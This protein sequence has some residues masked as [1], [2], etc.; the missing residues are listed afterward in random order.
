MAGSMT[1]T[2]GI[3]PALTIG[4]A[5]VNT[6]A[7]LG[8]ISY[9]QAGILVSEAGV[10]ASAPVF[11]GRINAEITS[12]ANTGFAVAN[13]N[14]SDATVSFFF[15]DSNGN[16]S[17]RGSLTLPAHGQMARFLDQAPFNAPGALSGTFAFSSNVP[18]SA[19]A[20]RGLINERS[21]FLVT[22]LPIANPD[23]PATGTVYFPHFADGGG[24][25]TQFVLVNP[26]DSQISGTFRYMD[27]AGQAGSSFTYTIDHVYSVARPDASYHSTSR[28]QHFGQNG[29][30]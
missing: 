23:Q 2:A 8:V 28:L 24:W 13:P 6:T 20:L 10:P 14:D 12:T 7:G 11:R 27:Q 5:E 30:G 3:S 22:T 1:L 19:I 21:E 29:R 25:T 4:S 18:V 9:R 16:D 17:G 15:T 26:T